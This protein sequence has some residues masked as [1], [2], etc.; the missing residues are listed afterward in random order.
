[1]AKLWL[2]KARDRVASGKW[3][4]NFGFSLSA[5]STKVPG[6]EVNLLIER[7]LRRLPRSC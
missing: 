3:I 4:F 5:G 1:M 2:D 6:G 7:F